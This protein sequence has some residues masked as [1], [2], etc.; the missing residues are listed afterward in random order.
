MLKVVS[1]LLL[2]SCLLLG[3]GYFEVKR[4]GAGIAVS[5]LL[6]YLISKWHGKIVIPSSFILMETV[7]RKYDFFDPIGAAIS[8]PIVNLPMFL[9]C[10]I[11]FVLNIVQEDVVVKMR[12]YEKEIRQLLMKFNPS[13]LHKVDDMLS[14]H[15]Y[16]EL[17]LY[18]ELKEQYSHEGDNNF[19]TTSAK[20]MNERL[21]L[22]SADLELIERA[23]QEGRS[24][25]R[26]KLGY[27]YDRF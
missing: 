26:Q 6:G 14:R 2:I 11:L 21:D 10:G 4:K 9:M 5:C 1:N 8:I 24:A 20:Y 25:I 19:K 16:H 13:M 18:H 12:P 7:L 15:K 22:P 3:F 17:E 23:K 27:S